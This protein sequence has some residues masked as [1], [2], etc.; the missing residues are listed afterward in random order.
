MS[1]RAQL[2]LLLAI[3]GFVVP[4]AMVIVF[5]ARHG[6]D[7]GQYLGDW[8][9]RLPSAQ[10]VADLTIVFVTFVA[11]TAWDGPR[12]GI[13]RWWVTIPAS[14]LVG[15]CFAVPLYLYLRERYSEYSKP[16]S[17]SAEPT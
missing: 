10:L 6:F 4:N 1:K 7:P 3:V 12:N 11:W 5:L 9:D 2:L 8:F 15:V 16:Q 14:L 17:R 13:R